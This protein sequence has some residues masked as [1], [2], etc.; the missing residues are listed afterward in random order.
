MHEA[1]LKQAIKDTIKKNGGI[2]AADLIMAACRELFYTILNEEYGIS[3]QEVESIAKASV[4]HSVERETTARQKQAQIRMLCEQ[5]KYDQQKA[6]TLVAGGILRIIGGEPIIHARELNEINALLIAL[7]RKKEESSS[8]TTNIIEAQELLEERLLQAIGQYE[9]IIKMIFKGIL[10]DPPGEDEEGDIKY[11]VHQELIQ[12]NKEGE[13][14]R[15][16]R[17]P[18]MPRPSKK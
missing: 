16:F 4:P 3:Q 8:P 11:V 10:K 18:G 9:S 5:F 1:F 15:E 13:E 2:V 12:Y 7:I 17:M 14:K 6:E